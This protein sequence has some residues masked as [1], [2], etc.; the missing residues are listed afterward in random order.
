[1]RYLTVAALLAS[2]ALS[3]CVPVALGA[4]AGYVGLQD[5]PVAQ[6]S[7]DTGTKIALKSALGHVNSDWM[8]SIGI[9]VYYGDVLLTG[10]VSTREEGEKVLD[11][12]RRTEGVKRVYNELFVG[13]AYSTAQRGRDAWISAQIQPR[14]LGAKD[15]YP[16]NYLITVVNNHVYIMGSA[17]SAA[18]HEHVLHVL[19]TT[20]GVAQVHDYLTIANANTVEQPDVRKNNFGAT[21][22]RQ[23]DPLSDAELD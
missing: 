1:M 3:A 7:E 12:V 21:P 4:G 16:L 22:S 23:A 2:T 18:E 9:D 15:A 8:T 20:R 17:G 10:I 5:R 19:R 14:L 11:I 13:A 6:T